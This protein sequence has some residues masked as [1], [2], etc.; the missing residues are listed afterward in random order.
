MHGVCRLEI[1]ALCDQYGVI[2]FEDT[3]LSGFGFDEDNRLMWPPTY[4]YLIEDADDI[5][6]GRRNAI[7][8]VSRTMHSQRPDV[9]P[10]NPYQPNSMYIPMDQDPLESSD[11]YFKPE[12]WWPLLEEEV[13]EKEKQKEEAAAEA[14]AAN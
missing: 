11:A 9:H 6:G 1:E 13:R 7:P 14:T 12:A 4:D 10:L 5:S 3:Y 2:K 8:I